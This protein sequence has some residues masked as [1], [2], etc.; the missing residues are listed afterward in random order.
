MTMTIQSLATISEATRMLA[1]AK[2]LEDVRSIRDLAEAARVYARARDLGIEAQNQATEVRLRAERRA[3]E[4]L[5]QASEAGQRVTGRPEKVSEAATLSDLGITRDQSSDWQAIAALPEP[6]FEAHIAATVAAGKP[7]T[8][9][10][11][12][13][14]SRMTNGL[15]SSETGDWHT[16]TEIIER[17]TRALGT[18]DLDPCAEG[19]CA[20][21]AVRH[22][23]EADDGLSQPWRGRVYMNPPYGTVIGDWIDKLATEVA[24]GNVTE[25]IALLPA[26]TDTAW[27]TRLPSDAL[28]FVTGRLRF[29]GAGP[30]PFPSVAAYLGS[31]PDRFLDAFADGGV[32]YRRVT[33]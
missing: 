3:G 9:A 19:A 17:V 15:M 12:V 7:L 4:L 18:I 5:A 14:Q 2:T 24:Y 20:I 25:A 21:P 8:T 31:T 28:C 26:R 1:Q 32:L 16:P 10:A 6:E 29:S 22:Y 11:A 27:W 30:A 23:T 13:R 33:R